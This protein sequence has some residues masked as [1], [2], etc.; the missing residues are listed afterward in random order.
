MAPRCNAQRNRSYHSPRLAGSSTAASALA[1]RWYVPSISRS[2][3]SP[4]FV[5]SRYL[6]SQMFN[7]ASCRAM[8]ASL[9]ALSSN[10]MF[11]NALDPPKRYAVT[12]PRSTLSFDRDGVP[13]VFRREK[14]PVGL[15]AQP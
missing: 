11:I 12:P 9:V 4:D 3:G 10:A 1:T 2:T 13:T 15:L 8:S 5:F 6:V 14:L 7:E